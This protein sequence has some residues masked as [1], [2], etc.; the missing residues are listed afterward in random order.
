MVRTGKVGLRAQHVAEEVRGVG[1]AGVVIGLEGMEHIVAVDN[2]VG[3]V[4][5]VAVGILQDEVVVIPLVPVDL[6]DEAGGSRL[7]GLQVRLVAVAALVK[8]GIVQRRIAVEILIGVDGGQLDVAGDVQRLDDTLF[9]AVACKVLGRGH[10]VAAAG[11]VAGE[12]DAVTVDVV[13]LIGVIIDVL[14][15]VIQ[16]VAL[17]GCLDLDALAVFIQLVAGGC[18][19]A[20]AAGIQAEHHKASAGE[21]DAVLPLGLLGA[22]EAG[23]HEHHGSGVGGA[24]R[25]GLVNVKGIAVHRIVDDIAPPV[26]GGGIVFLRHGLRQGLGGDGDAAAA[27]LEAH[28]ADTGQQ[29][30]HQGNRQHPDIMLL[31]LLNRGF[32]SLLFFTIV[33]QGKH[34]GRRGRNA[35]HKTGSGLFPRFPAIV[36]QDAAVKGDQGQHQPQ[37]AGLTVEGKAPGRAQHINGG[38]EIRK[39]RTDFHKRTLIFHGSPP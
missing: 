23:H 2:P 6:V 9:K 1:N 31:S 4:L 20:L 22:G 16:A 5:L 18:G 14:H 37:P 3:A 12:A 11:G 26:E 32:G 7:K 39:N 38:A 33:N 21:L 36:Q 27:G 19:I 28:G 30:H 35:Q 34:K 25:L 8:A 15:Q 17:H 13:K 10:H 24:G 29:H